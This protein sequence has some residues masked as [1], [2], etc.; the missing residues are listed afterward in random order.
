MNRCASSSHRRRAAFAIAW[1]LAG[2]VAALAPLAAAARNF[3][4][5]ALRGKLALTNPPDV[6]LNGR[7]ARLSAAMRIHGVD[8]MLV[9]TGGLPPGTYLVDYTLDSTGLIYE[10]WILTAQEAA[11]GPWPRSAE[12]AAAWRF[13]PIGQAWTKP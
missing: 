5:T 1:A 2:S 8:N 10:I 9:M 13:D 12:E 3:P 6:V 11:V 4:A 7:P